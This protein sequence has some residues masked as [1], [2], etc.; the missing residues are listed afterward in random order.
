MKEPGAYEIQFGN[1]GR[2]SPSGGMLDVDMNISGETRTPVE[3]I[4]YSS[5]RTMK[6]GRYTFQVH[7]YNKRETADV[8]FEVEI[9]ILGQTYSFAYPKAVAHNETV[10]VAEFEYTRAGGIKLLTNLQGNKASRSI[11][12]VATN[13]FCKVNLMLLSPNHWDGCGIGNKHYFFVLDKC[14]SDVPARGFL[15]EFLKSEL[16]K[17]RKVFEVLGSKLQ[18]PPSE[19]Q[20]SGLGF[21]STQ[22]NSLICRVSG[23]FTRTLRV[24]F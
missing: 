7:N 14:I 4:F 1:K 2:L 12:G 16:D 13:T 6:E 9:E 8:G 24:M 10:T 22:R 17:H 20:L 11:W 5:Q 3:N 18:V 23:S 15:N 19:C 21:S